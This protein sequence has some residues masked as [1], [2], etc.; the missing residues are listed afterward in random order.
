[1]PSRGHDDNF[2][3]LNRHSDGR[4]KLQT[5][6]FAVLLGCL[7]RCDTAW[8]L[9]KTDEASVLILSLATNWKANPDDTTKWVVTLREDVNFYVV[10]DEAAPHFD[11]SQDGVTGLAHDVGPPAMSNK[12]KGVAQPKSWFIDIAPMDTE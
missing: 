9:S 12:V 5:K 1:M 4:F 11:P 6:L 2:L 8:G 3:W 7:N 10:P